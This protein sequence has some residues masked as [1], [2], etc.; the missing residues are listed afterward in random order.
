MDKG[1]EALLKDIERIQIE[2]MNGEF[3]D[4]KNQKYP[5]PKMALI[6]IFSQMI[7]NVKEGKYDN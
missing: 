5:A 7:I 4:F 1:H 2:A 3:H 6:N